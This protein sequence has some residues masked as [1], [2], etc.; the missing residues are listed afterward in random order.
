MG[1][2][3]RLRESDAIRRLVDR[4]PTLFSD[5]ID[6]R[7]PIMQ[8]LG[9]TDLAEA[10][11]GRLPLVTNLAASLASAGATDIVL[12]GMGGSSLAPLVIDRIAGPREGSPRLHVL[13]TTSPDAVATL[14]ER[15]EPDSTYFV[16]SSKSGTTIEPLSLYAIFRGWMDEHMERPAAGQHFIAI[17]DPGTP[18]E[19]MRQRD[20]MRVALPAPPTVGG[21]FSALSVFGLAPAAMA[22]VDVGTLV[23]RAHVM[24]TACHGD[25]EENPAALLAAFMMDAYSDGRDKLTLAT[26]E[27]YRP[28][29]LWVEQLVAESTGKKGLGIVPV[30]DWKPTAP[31]GYGTDRTV[32]IM[33][34][35]A[36]TSMQGFADAA[37]AE[38]HPVME[39]ELA[40]EFDIGAH[41]VLWEHAVALLGHLMGINPFDEPNVAEAKAAT[42]AV[43][44]G[45][46][47][48]P[49]AVADLEGVWPTYAGAL[50]GASA[51][52][53]LA[54]ALAPLAVTLK[55]GDYLAVLAYISEDS[56]AVP[57]FQHALDTVSQALKVA[58]CFEIGP[59]Y[60]HSTG[61]LHKGG[62]DKGVF[63][64]ITTRAHT[65]VTIPGQHFSLAELFRAQ[66]EGDLVTLAAQGKRIMRLD[67]PG[68]DAATLT[69][70]AD[71]LTAALY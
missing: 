25:V 54:S 3:A 56:P 17:T 42:T 8:R 35:A 61:Q 26:S 38:G 51:P 59:R 50:A 11:L 71:A 63:L 4:D 48:V 33:R 66:A 5:E 58:T 18:L 46:A 41:F 62:P 53:D 27:R 52:P 57:A 19:K 12:L 67:L 70:V 47:A 31:T 43:L 65:T 68:D 55:Q 29:G 14:L 64:M 10:A 15:L 40:D 37:R 24:E 45:S 21:R 28:F 30:L 9:W 32:V 23:R 39:Y 1:S 44:G 2:L 16:L 13:D 36:D 49:S 22:G 34:S 20:V 6:L 69:A 7:Q 60:L